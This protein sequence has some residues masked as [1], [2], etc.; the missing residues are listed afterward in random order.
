MANFFLSPP[1]SFLIYFFFEPTFFLSDSVKR[2]PGFFPPPRISPPRFPAPPIDSPVLR[3]VGLSLFSHRLL[4]LVFFRPSSEFRVRGEVPPP[5]A[6]FHPPWPPVL[7]C[8]SFRYRSLAPPPFFGMSPPPFAGFWFLFGVEIYFC[9]RLPPFLSFTIQLTVLGSDPIF[10]CGFPCPGASFISQPFFPLFASDSRS[11]FLLFIRSSAHPLVFSN[12]RTFFVPPWPF[13]LGL[14]RCFFMLLGP[15]F[16]FF[17]F[18]CLSLPF[19][20][21]IYPP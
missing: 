15:P 7:L 16:F 2:I 4:A 18:F 8:F 19:P 6:V 13:P 17:F 5:K 11:V 14:G 12:P 20:R 3:L 9:T 10:S 1:N 21:P